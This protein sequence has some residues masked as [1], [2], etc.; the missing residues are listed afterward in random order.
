MDWGN[1]LKNVILWRIFSTE[2]Q[3]VHYGLE[4]DERKQHKSH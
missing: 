4:Y 3:I 1:F 2:V